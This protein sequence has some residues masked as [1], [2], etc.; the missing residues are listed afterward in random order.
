MG[1]YLLTTLLNGEGQ[2][3]H[4]HIYTLQCGLLQ[5]LDLLFHYG[6]KGQVRGE[7]PRPVGIGR[8]HGSRSEFK[9][10]KCRTRTICGTN[11]KE[12]QM[13]AWRQ[14][15]KDRKQVRDAKKFN[16]EQKKHLNED[17]KERRVMGVCRNSKQHRRK[18]MQVRHL[19]SLSAILKQGSAGT[20]LYP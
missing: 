6:L 11:R 16:M 2:F 4:Y 19:F 3:T 15:E 5:L 17:E 9:R 20:L 14:K 10:R 18:K 1:F 13:R 12:K 8:H 7:Q